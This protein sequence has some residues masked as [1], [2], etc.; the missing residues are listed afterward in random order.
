MGEREN[1]LGGIDELS[2][3]DLC[4][5]DEEDRMGN[6]KCRTRICQVEHGVEPLIEVRRME[7]WAN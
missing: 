3:V 2:G 7:T 4:M 1:P 5:H 6:I